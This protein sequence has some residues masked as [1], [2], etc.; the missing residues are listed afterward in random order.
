M[1]LDA[2]SGSGSEPVDERT[3]TPGARQQSDDSPGTS[4]LVRVS[5]S[6]EADTVTVAVS[7][8]GPGIPEH[9]LE[10]LERGEETP[11]EHGSGIGLWIVYWIA[12]HA[13]VTVSF[14]TGDDGTTVTVEI[15][16][17]ATASGSP[18]SR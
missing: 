13:T 11:L 2:S 17:D 1:T 8:N 6:I 7:D 4:P 14:E 10:V 3:E 15:P 18:A 12:E 16:R 9:E 5:G